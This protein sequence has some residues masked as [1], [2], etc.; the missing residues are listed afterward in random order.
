[1]K[2]NLLKSLFLSL[3][4]FIMSCDPTYD[5]DYEVLNSSGESISIIVNFP[6]NRIDT[7]TIANRTR[8][9]FF[10]DFNIG[11]TTE[12]YLDNLKSIDLDLSIFNSKGIKFNKNVSD[13]SLWQKSYPNRYSSL[14][15]VQLT[16]R[17]EDFE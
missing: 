16:V 2:S 10:N 14:G 3:S 12:D 17:S 9:V 15:K 8:L 11:S 1:M 5:V 4:L 7:S 6:F 13:I